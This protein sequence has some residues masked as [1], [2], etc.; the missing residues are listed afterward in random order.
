MATKLCKVPKN[1]FCILTWNIIINKESNFVFSFK[2]CR[3]DVVFRYIIKYV[4]RE[5]V[6]MVTN[7]TATSNR[8]ASTYTRK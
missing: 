2:C 5:C 8:K 4:A 6:T 7:H 1:F 3:N